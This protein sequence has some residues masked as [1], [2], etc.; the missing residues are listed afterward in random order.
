MKLYPCRVFMRRALTRHSPP[1][2]VVQPDERLAPALL[3]GLLALVTLVLTI[4]GLYAAG[5]MVV[6]QRTRELA[7]RMALGTRG[8]LGAMDGARRGDAAGG[9]VGAERARRR[10]AADAG[11]RPVPARRRQFTR[12]RSLS[13][14]P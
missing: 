3:A 2:A 8:D 13:R 12:R 7:I 9:G 4:G 14:P 6:G 11:L 10:R 1:A 5:T